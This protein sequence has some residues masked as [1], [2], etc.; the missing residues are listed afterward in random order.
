MVLMDVLVHLILVLQVLL[1]NTAL[2]LIVVLVHHVILVFW[3]LLLHNTAQ[4]LMVVLVL[5]HLILMVFQVLLHDRALVLHTFRDLHI[6]PQESAGLATV[7][8]PAH[9]CPIQVHPNL[10]FL[11]CNFFSSN[12]PGKRS[13]AFRL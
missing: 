9:L 5:H 10:L 4:V 11:R 13:K 3:L 6:L 2:V 8:R 12:W 7:Q 1:H